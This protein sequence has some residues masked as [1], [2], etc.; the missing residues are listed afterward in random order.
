VAGN[1]DV[2]AM[3]NDDLTFEVEATLVY[4]HSHFVVEGACETQME[5]FDIALDEMR[6]I[7]WL[8]DA[9]VGLG[10]SP[11]LTPRQIRYASN[12]NADALRRGTE[13]EQ[14]AIDGYNAHIAAIADPK[15]QRMLAHIRDEEVDHLDEFTELLEKAEKAPEDRQPTVGDMTGEPQ[16]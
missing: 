3:L 13:L 5:A 14:E 16:A 7:E 4:M 15:I 9:I 2:I 12:E 6:H 10:G 11:E 1:D 8:S